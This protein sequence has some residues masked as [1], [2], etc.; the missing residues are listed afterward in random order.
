MSP[1]LY[2]S[3]FANSISSS[4]IPPGERPF[5]GQMVCVRL[6]P[7]AS[8][9]HW[10]EQFYGQ[11]PKLVY[12]LWLVPAIAMSDWREG[13]LISGL[14]LYMSGEE[15]AVLSGILIWDSSHCHINPSNSGHT[16]KSIYSVVYSGESYRH[17]AK[18]LSYCYPSLSCT[19]S[20]WSVFIRNSLL[21]THILLFGPE[22]LFL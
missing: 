15:L 11:L 3:T 1:S 21:Y 16:A 9:S 12:N 10:K 13:A 7:D 17:T 19:G 22:Q 20:Q 8:V 4:V 2:T 18:C 14:W 5:P 6:T